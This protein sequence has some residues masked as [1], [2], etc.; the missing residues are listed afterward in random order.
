MSFT[1]LSC[2]TFLKW[3]LDEPD[4]VIEEALEDDIEAFTG[5]SIDLT[6]LSGSETL[7]R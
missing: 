4:N 2:N 5:L 6:P 1:L 7:G 3:Q